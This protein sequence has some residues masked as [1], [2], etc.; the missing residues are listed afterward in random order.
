MRVWIICYTKHAVE[1]GW[2]GI[3][4]VRSFEPP[5]ANCAHFSKLL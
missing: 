2:P 3:I 1:G 5:D 4:M